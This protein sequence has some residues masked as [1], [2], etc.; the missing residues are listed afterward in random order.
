[1]PNVGDFW[2]EGLA[3]SDLFEAVSHAFKQAQ[4]Q[5][6]DITVLKYLDLNR[7]GMMPVTTPVAVIRKS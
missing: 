3:T 2:C 4:A 1:M 7:S 5:G 6:R